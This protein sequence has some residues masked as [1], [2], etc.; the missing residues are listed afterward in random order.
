MNVLKP[1]FFSKTSLSLLKQLE[2][3]LLCLR[4]DSYAWKYFFWR[5]LAI[6]YIYYIKHI[7]SHKSLFLSF[8]SR[9]RI[10]WLIS[11]RFSLSLNIILMFWRFFF[12]SLFLLFFLFFLLFLFLD[13]LRFVIL[14]LETRL[15]WLI[16]YFLAR[17]VF[18]LD[19][20]SKVFDGKIF[21]N[22]LQVS[23]Y[24]SSLAYTFFTFFFLFNSFYSD[25]FLSFYSHFL[26]FLSLIEFNRRVTDRL[27]SFRAAP[28]SESILENLFFPFSLIDCFRHL[29]DFFQKFL[30]FFIEIVRLFRLAE[31]QISLR[32]MFYKHVNQFSVVKDSETTP[33]EIMLP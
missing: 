26:S 29:I 12:F 30:S 23:I 27:D 5:W 8:L 15:I 20:I 6:F 16:G 4:W 33:L 18:Y 11:F 31:R 2:I 1:V 9:S 13:L 14:R 22:V 19:F 24:G 25:G 17:P 21:C 28:P 32:C 10:N 3:Y 7:L